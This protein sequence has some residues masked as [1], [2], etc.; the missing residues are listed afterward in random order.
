MHSEFLPQ[1][2]VQLADS[3]IAYH[4]QW[5]GLRAKMRDDA[6]LC[7]H[8]AE[9]LETARPIIERELSD[10]AVTSMFNRLGQALTEATEKWR[11]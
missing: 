10:E 7:A 1:L 11:G 6:R 2:K 9:F 3:V 8:P 5:D 4:N